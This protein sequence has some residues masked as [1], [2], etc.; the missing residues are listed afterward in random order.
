MHLYAFICVFYYIHKA[1]FNSR[2][3]IQLIYSEKSIMM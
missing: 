2:V 3:E 1:K